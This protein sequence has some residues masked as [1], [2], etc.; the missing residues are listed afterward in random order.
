MY[1]ELVGMIEAEINHYTKKANIDLVMEDWKALGGS[2]D[3]IILKA[4]LIGNIYGTSRFLFKSY[5]SNPDNEETERFKSMMVYKVKGMD[6]IFSE[7]LENNK[8]P[9]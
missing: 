9:T 6:K 8:E 3:A 1:D 2:P 7:Y 5:P 4:F